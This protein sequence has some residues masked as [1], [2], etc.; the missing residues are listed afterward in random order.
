[1]CSFQDWLMGAVRRLAEKAKQE[2]EK[3]ETHL[4]QLLELLGSATKTSLDLQLLLGN[5]TFNWVLRRRD[6]LLKES[7]ENLSQAAKRALRHH[8]LGDRQLFGDEQCAEAHTTMVSTAQAGLFSGWNRQSRGQ[9]RGFRSPRSNQRQ[10]SSHGRNSSNNRG[11]SPAKDS[12]PRWNQSKR[13]GKSNAHSSNS[14][15]KRGGRGRK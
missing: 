2:P 7:H 6:A 3:A 10:S 13:G 15:S 8:D 12:T 9:S 11:R 1:M 14:S 5:L 4:E